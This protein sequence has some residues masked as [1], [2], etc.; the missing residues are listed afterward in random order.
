MLGKSTFLICGEKIMF[1]WGEVGA[2]DFEDV[3]KDW[4]EE[5]L[6]EHE[7]WPWRANMLHKPGGKNDIFIDFHFQM[8]YTR[9]NQGFII[10]AK[11]YRSGM[12]PAFE[13]GFG[14]LERDRRRTRAKVGIL[15]MS[16]ITAT[17]KQ[18]E[19]MIDERDSHA[20]QPERLEEKILKDLNHIGYI[21]KDFKS[22]LHGL[23]N[24]IEDGY[25]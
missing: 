14:K 18:K 23:M 10:D 16:P 24:D 3:M 17:E 11:H 6:H 5:A 20:C 8:L 2:R 1:D 9:G 7:E 25:L 19:K 13:H 12:R 21:K 15:V 22:Y 4:I